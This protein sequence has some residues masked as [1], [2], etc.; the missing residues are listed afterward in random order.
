MKT[1]ERDEGKKKNQE[2]KGK[3]ELRKGVQKSKK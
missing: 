1:S 2:K 3:D